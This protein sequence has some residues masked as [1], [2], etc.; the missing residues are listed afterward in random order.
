MTAIANKIPASPNWWLPVRR[1]VLKFA[2]ASSESILADPKPVITYISRQ[3]R[4][5]SL[6]QEDHDGLVEA[7]KGLETRYGW[8]VN[9]AIMEKYSKLEQLR[10]AART[11][12]RLTRV[13]TAR[14]ALV[15][16]GEAFRL[17]LDP[18]RCPRQ[19]AHI[20]A[21]DATESQRDRHRDL[22]PWRI[23][24][25]LSGHRERYRDRA[26]RLLG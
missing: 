1:N 5:R 10:L 8:E 14:L 17:L 16:T 20:P 19:W 21:L 13:I 9:I 15:L 2:G 3:G 18:D 4:G 12:V 25:R 6:V 11:T 23:L 24:R 22:L 26:L 7:L